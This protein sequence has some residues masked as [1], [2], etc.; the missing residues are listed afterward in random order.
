MNGF[1]ISVI[2]SVFVFYVMKYNNS[3]KYLNFLNVK[4]HN[5]VWI[6]W[7]RTRS[8]R[9]RMK[10]IIQSTRYSPYHFSEHLTLFLQTHCIIHF[11]LHLTLSLKT[12][13]VIHSTT[14]VYT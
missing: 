14:L 12:Q 11:S 1:H 2:E 8:V 6:L 4:V 13:Y 3:D 5:N 10:Y 7:T 9:L